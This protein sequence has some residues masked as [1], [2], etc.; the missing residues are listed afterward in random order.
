MK[1]HNI[2]NGDNQK[3]KN[4]TGTVETRA[5]SGK[6]RSLSSFWIQLKIRCDA[7]KALRAEPDS[8]CNVWP[9]RLLPGFYSSSKFLVH[10][11]HAEYFALCPCLFQFVNLVIPF[12]IFSDNPSFLSHWRV[13]CQSGFSRR[14]I[15][16]TRARLVHAWHWAIG[17]VIDCRI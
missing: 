8:F 5:P 13:S 2:N 10:L 12:E 14:D 1:G 15:I 16:M 3:N 17:K 4:E 11:L 9:S 7:L 6:Q